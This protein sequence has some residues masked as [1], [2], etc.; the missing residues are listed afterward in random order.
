MWTTGCPPIRS[1]R[2]MRC[3]MP[4]EVPRK[5]EVVEQVAGLEVEPLGH[6]VRADEDPVLALAERCLDRAL[7]DLAPRASNGVVHFAAPPGVAADLA[8]PDTG[9]LLPQGIHRVGE[10]GE[11]DR[12]PRTPVRLG[13]TDL[14]TQVVHEL[15]ELGVVGRP[16]LECLQERVELLDLRG[17]RARGLGHV[18]GGIVAVLNV[19]QAD[20]FVRDV[21]E[22]GAVVVLEKRGEVEEPV[23]LLGEK[24][25]PLSQRQ[26]DGLEGR[27]QS[28]SVNR[29]D[30]ASSAS[31]LVPLGSSLRDLRVLVPDPG[32]DAVVQ[33]LFRRD[34]VLTL[35]ELDVEVTDLAPRDHDVLT[36][37]ARVLVGT[38]QVPRVA[39][40]ERPHRGVLTEPGIQPGQFVALHPPVGLLVDGL[41]ELHDLLRRRAADRPFAGLLPDRVLEV[42]VVSGEGGRM[43]TGVAAQ[44]SPVT[45]IG[46]LD[47]ELFVVAV[48]PDS[49]AVRPCHIVGVLR[50]R[51][52]QA[53]DGEQVVRLVRI[54]LHRGRRREQHTLPR[55]GVPHAAK[56]LQECVGV[57]LGRLAT[58]TSSVVGFVDDDE[59]P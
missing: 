56:Q 59:I 35:V 34:A 8:R 48:E 27:R 37:D 57:V 22:R 17:G 11:H 38:E 29:H 12:L 1:M 19:E 47:D 50:M 25:A 53:E 40:D 45:P 52:R 30:K 9:Q 46:V 5:V 43:G 58:S 3:S 16:V 21:L 54:H 23:G 44:M 41:G 14:G 4:H 32:L 10:L 24:V 15:L 31:L 26:L 49:A 13:V 55:L 28:A 2:P 6:R 20:E 33:L 7:V 42:R 36:E 51:A 18:E 39:V